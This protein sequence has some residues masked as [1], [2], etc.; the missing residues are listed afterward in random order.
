VEVTDLDSSSRAHLQVPARIQGALIS[1]VD[2]DSAS[3][4][5]GLREGDVITE[6]DRKPVINAEQAVAACAKPTGKK[7]LLQVW[8]HGSKRYVVVDETQAG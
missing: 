8:S 6:I 2:P 3:F 1:Q 5:A 7:T 4:E